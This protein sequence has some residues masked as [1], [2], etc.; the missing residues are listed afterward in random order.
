MMTMV[1]H[2]I[3]LHAQSALRTSQE[4]VALLAY[5]RCSGL[6]V[7]QRR[8]ETCERVKKHQ[9]AGKT[10]HH[11][12]VICLFCPKLGP[13]C[14]PGFL[15]S[16]PTMVPAWLEFFLVEVEAVEGSH[17]G[18]N[19]SLKGCLVSSIF[20]WRYGEQGARLPIPYHQCSAPMVPPFIR[21]VSQSSSSPKSRSGSGRE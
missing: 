10:G 3:A 9:K 2:A 12:K 18:A 6:M 4:A 7:C 21:L 1:L 8:I 17:Q 14:K 11:F 20:Y 15:F 13:S 16:G 19:Y 5:Y